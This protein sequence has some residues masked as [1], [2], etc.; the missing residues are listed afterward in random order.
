MKSKKPKVAHE[1]LGKPLVRWVVDAAHEVGIEHVVC[2]VGHAREQVIPLVEHDTQ[3]VVQAEQRGTADAVAACKDA[4]A[5]FDGS[6]VV[7]SATARSSRPTPSA[8]W[9]TCARSRVPP[10]WC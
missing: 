2:V 1:V 10:W 8:A 7:L 3:V 9:W 6:L 5:G 4:L